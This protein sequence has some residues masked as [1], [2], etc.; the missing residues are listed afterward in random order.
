MWPWLAW[1]LNSSPHGAA[2]CPG[3]FYSLNEARVEDWPTGLQK[4][5]TDMKRGENEAKVPYDLVYVC[6][7][8][9][10]A[11]FVM[12]RGGMACNPRSHLRLIYEGNPMALVVEEAGGLGSTG[13][14]PILDVQPTKVCRQLHPWMTA[15]GSRL[16]LPVAGGA[17]VHERLPV[18]LGSELDIRELESYGVKYGGVQQLGTKTYQQ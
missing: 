11:F 8:V 13:V 16:L 2:T 4:Y 15:V 17:Q 18:F 1:Q 12:I 6:S 14:G 3:P 7:L 10:D 9:A 5:I